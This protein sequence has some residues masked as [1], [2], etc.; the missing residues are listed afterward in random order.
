M[1]VGDLALELAC[2]SSAIA[3]VATCAQRLATRRDRER[4]PPGRPV[5]AFAVASDQRDV[6]PSI[7]VPLMTPIAV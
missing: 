4:S 7:D 2:G 6:D 3:R 1:C 5:P